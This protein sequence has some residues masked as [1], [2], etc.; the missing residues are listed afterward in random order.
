[1]DSPAETRYWIDDMYMLTMLQLEAYRAT[2]DKK[3]LDRDAKEM[4]AYLDKLQQPNGLFF[5]APD[6][7]YLLGSRRWLG[8]GGHGGDADDAA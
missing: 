2:G 4:V 7:K 8:R 5:H 1:M 3:Y 6:V